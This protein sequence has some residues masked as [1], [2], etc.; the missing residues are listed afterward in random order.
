[1]HLGDID[2]EFW[3]VKV[4]GEG[5]GRVRHNHVD[6]YCETDEG[7]KG[8]FHIDVEVAAGG[9]ERYR[10]ECCLVAAI[11]VSMFDC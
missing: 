7:A 9:V 6:I 1:M 4:D 5:D 10:I 11:A 3:N 8:Q 2:V